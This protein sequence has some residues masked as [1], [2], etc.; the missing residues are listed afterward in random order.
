MALRRAGGAVIGVTQI[1]VPLSVDSV[2]VVFSDENLAPGDYVVP[3]GTRIGF[4]LNAVYNVDVGWAI[5]GFEPDWCMPA[6]LADL[7]T[8]GGRRARI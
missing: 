2:Q 8:P 3:A 6:W 7:L 5:A 4:A 1:A